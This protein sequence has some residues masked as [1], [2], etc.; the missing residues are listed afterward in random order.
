MTSNPL[1]R[2]RETVDASH[3]GRDARPGEIVSIFDSKNDRTI[4]FT[5][6]NRSYPEDLCDAYNDNISSD[7]YARGLRW[8]VAHDGSLFL[9]FPQEFSTKLT[10]DLADAR[11]RD[12]Q[13][14]L[15]NYRARQ[16]QRE[17][18]GA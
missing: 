4:T 16:N 12:R 5:R 3:S 9:G 2:R 13:I 10:R 15:R 6:T 17:M 18:V 8:M 7:A 14:W 1:S 11:E